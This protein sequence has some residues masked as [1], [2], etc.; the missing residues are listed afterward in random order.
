G[1]KKIVLIGASNSMLFNGLRAG[2]NQDNVELTNLSLGGA[3]TLHILYE[4]LRFRNESIVIAADLIILESNIV[5]IDHII[6]LPDFKN[7]ILRNIFLT[8]NEL[9]KLN[10]KFLVLLLPL[11]E[12]HSDYNVVETINNAHRMCCNQY[13]FN[14]VDVQSV[15]LKN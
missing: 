10:K 12:K 13:G 15:Y 8:Y 2:L 14:C 4:F 6:D 5:D 11:L 9:S 3:S 7:L 1:K